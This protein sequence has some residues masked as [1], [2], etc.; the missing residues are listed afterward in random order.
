MNKLLSTIFILAACSSL[1]IAKAD[2]IVTSVKYLS[3]H[4]CDDMV[5]WEFYC[6][7]GANSG[8]WTTIGVPSCW[9][10]QGFGVTQYGYSYN[11]WNMFP[12]TEPIADETG[13][14]RY[15]FQIPREWK[16]MQ[17]E[18]VF[19][20]AMTDTEVKVNGSSAGDMHQG[21]FSP[22]RYDITDKLRYGG[23]DNL[24]EVKV[25]KESGNKTMNLAERRC[26]FWNFGGIIRPVYLVAKP[27]SNIERVAICA[28][29]DGNFHADCF[30]KNVGE[31]WTI[32]AAILDDKG[33]QLA[34]TVSPVRIDSL[35]T[36]LH[37]KRPHLW[38]AE[39]PCLYIALFSLVNPQGKV[40][41]Q[42]RQKFGFRTIEVKPKDGIYVNGKK[43]MFKG[44]NRH[45]FR[46]ETGRTL[47]KEK[48]I[49]DVLLVK[50]MNMNAVRLSHYP[51]D[52]GFYDA[53]DS[54]GLYVLDELTG[55]Q[56]PQETLVGKKLVREMVTRDV[57]HPSIV[58]WCSGNEGGFNYGLESC[59]QRY[60]IQHR[61]VIYP[62]SETRNGI[63]TRHYRS[64]DDTKK[65]LES[66]D[67]F[68]PTEFL[69]G[70]Y[71]GGSG[72]GLYDYW[73]LMKRYPNSAGG[74]L[75]CL[76]DE[77]FLRKDLGGKI[78]CQG[79]LAADGI[80]G[81]HHEKEGSYYTVRQIWSP[82]QLAWH[83][84]S[85]SITNDYDFLTLKGCKVVCEWFD[86]PSFGEK[87]SL[88]KTAIVKAPS[89]QPK[90][91]GK[92]KLPVVSNAGM[93]RLSA[94]NVEGDTLFTW[95][96]R[97]CK[98][99]TPPLSNVGYTTT[100]SIDRL[101]ITV[102]DNVYSLSE[103]SGELK[104]VTVGGKT[105]HFGNGPR[106]VAA[107]RAD[108]GRNGVKAGSM[109]D[110]CS[111]LD[112]AKFKGFTI[113]DSTLV[114]NYDGGHLRQ[115]EWQFLDNGCVKVNV[116]Y[117]F[118]KVVD[119]M[120]V[121]FDYP[122]KQVLAKQWVGNGPYR[123]WQNRLQGPQYGYWQTKYNNPIPGESFEYP[124]FKGYFSNVDWMQVETT[125]GNVGI[126]NLD[127]DNYVC[128][129]K[130]EDGCDNYLYRL[131]DTG[132]SILK[133]IPAVRNKIDY[134]DKN[135]P[136]AQPHMAEGDY[137]CNFLLKFQ[138]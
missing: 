77:G 29:M 125:E 40:V 9:E 59:F 21:G 90:E 106:F 41:H 108:R 103:T 65:Y 107:R 105:I 48:N 5:P 120:G 58:L 32:K 27:K 138:N 127:S 113:T 42:A 54:L 37:V 67:I 22:F 56:T 97:L 11:V 35:R 135:G 26:D 121:M 64:W 118:N 110:Y 79:N 18:I 16:G 134:S 76:A 115:V 89:L 128:V 71:D 114:C 94:L 45:S 78:D 43:V 1:S 74:F 23:E 100:K 34:R 133:F 3:G 102:G 31:G 91:S 83:D 62:W 50:S 84:D 66:G 46:P 82:I 2:G 25:S 12:S 51:A 57:N 132:I 47:S 73:Q 85:L 8:K 13:Y 33:R 14:Y 136:S 20:A 109:A 49:E 68:M 93:L 36:H 81:P 80:V 4:G 38:T 17:I 119:L 101:N 104:Q 10:A 129:Y 124:E 123:V 87:P 44:V 70:L 28:D 92:V 53:C 19:E 122:E 112:D 137:E 117:N 86:N 88:L 52:P 131:P 39:T 60:D 126:V 116:K 30:L 15:H 130:P 111:Y 63:C 96:K 69:H 55:W 24:L 75:W 72:A 98:P 61:T 7:D 95:G 6:T 99:V